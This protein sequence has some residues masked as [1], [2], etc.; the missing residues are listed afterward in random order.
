MDKANVAEWLLR[1]VV[2]PTRASELVGDQ[3]EAHPAEKSRFWIS[4]AQLLVMF[5]WRTA[6]GVA[7][8]PV[9]GSFLAFVFFFFGNSKP[10][11]SITYLPAMTIHHTTNYLLGISVL[12]WAVTVFSIV[13]LGWR[14]TLTVVGLMVSTLCSA[15]LPFYWQ[16]TPA[17]VLAILWVC[18]ITFCVSRAKWRQAL[19]ILCTAVAIGWLAAFAISIFPPRDAHSIFG[20]WQGVAALFLVPILENSVTMFLHRRSIMSQGASL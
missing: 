13:R 11:M 18:F 2:D 16:R 20:K 5:S 3:L 15:S 17:I 10:V 8:S 12:L 6:I 7:A 9:V 19:G 1:R 14:S 4:I